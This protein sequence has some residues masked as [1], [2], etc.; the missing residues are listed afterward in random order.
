MPLVRPSL[1]VPLLLAPALAVAAPIPVAS[2]SASS[3]YPADDSGSYDAKRVADGKISTAWVEGESGNGLGASV[4]LDLGGKKDVAKVRIWG[5]MWYSVEYWE[6]SSRPTELEIAFSDGSKELVKVPDAMKMFEHTFSSPKS[7][8]NL[9]F[10]L[11]NVKS[12]S[13]W[14]DTGISEIQVFDATPGTL[15]PVR[16]VTA[17]STAPRDADGDYDP[18]NLVDGVSDS[19]WCEGAGDGTN[20]WV[21]LQLGSKQTISK[22]H[23][24]NG[25]GT[26]LKFFM[27]A[28]RAG[29]VTLTFGDGSTQTVAV[30]NTMLPQ[31]VAFTPVSTDKVKLTV[32]EVVKGKEIDDLCLSEVGFSQ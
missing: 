17:S 6:R 3:E 24:N 2:V 27:K 11:K 23:L 21:E 16:A 13:T 20:E 19:M 7:T 9:K 1:I 25:I 32:S 10:T 5:G 22:L 15:A 28:N 26:S 12:G 29:K 14:S 4:T 8:T 31:E 30:K 18:M